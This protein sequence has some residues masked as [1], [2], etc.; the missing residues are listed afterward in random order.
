MATQ[1][2]RGFSIMS[3]L[4]PILIALAI[5]GLII[6]S[7]LVS[8]ICFAMYVYKKA[9]KIVSNKMAN[10]SDVTKQLLADANK[11]TPLNWKQMKN[12]DKIYSANCCGGSDGSSKQ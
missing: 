5:I 12:V 1:T 2:V 9:K 6:L 10:P 8:T 7:L 3:I 11:G 4:Q